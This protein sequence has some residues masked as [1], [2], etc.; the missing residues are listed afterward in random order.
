MP[1]HKSTRL[2][3]TAGALAIVVSSGWSLS[4]AQ[5][6]PV[7]RA[8]RQRAEVLGTDRAGGS[9]TVREDE[10]ELGD[11]TPFGVDVSGLRL[12]SHQD[13]ATM[14]PTVSEAI[15]IDPELPA[16]AGL[17]EVLQ[18]Y[19]G[20]PLSMALLGRLG[21]D[22]VLAWRESDYPLVDVYFPEQNITQGKIQVVVREAVLGE[23]RQEGAVHSRPDYILENLRLESGDR[24][25][26]RVVQGDLDWLN[27][28]P[29]RQVNVI[30]ERGTEDGTSDIVMDVNE[31]KQL[32][33]Y[34]SFA[35]TGVE[36]T[37]ENEFS[38]G[39]N[40]ANPWQTEQGI[41]YQYTADID[42][43]YLNAHTLFYQN[44][45]PWRHT[46][47]IIGAYVTSEARGLGPLGLNGESSQVSTE[48][49]VPLPRPDWNRGW[50]HAVTAAFDYKATNTDLIFGGFNV[51]ASDIAIGQFRFEYD[52]S[53]PDRFGYSRFSAGI[54][55]SPGDMYGNNDD[56]SFMLARPGSEADYFYSFVECEKL[57]RLPQD[58]SLRLN[59]NAQ[60][61]GDRL[62]STEQLLAGGYATVRGY[63]E[64]VVRGDAGAIFNVEVI[65]PPFSL[66]D[67]IEDE[68]NAFVFY[69]GAALQIEDKLPGEFSPSLQSVGLGLN[70]RFSDRGFA[71]ASY[72]WAI[73]NHGVPLANQ[74]DGRFHFGV[75]LT[76]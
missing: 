10:D 42:F 24:I 17:E 35:N 37:G 7:E 74:G 63:D 67:E 34:T 38:F 54:V 11:D 30:Y 53:F 39:V 60:A 62:A 66:C 33:A 4:H 13:K 18:P 32:T 36:F 28:N 26:R 41:G 69:D 73:D 55:G 19:I 65:T 71:R 27:E 61:S 6:R 22:I 45:L 20:E 1:K 5:N 3:F 8:E 15:V 48:Y 76:Y 44:F 40:L 2:R 64:S 46:L 51:F 21:K 31:E 58:W 68:W 52:A 14:D 75:T 50:R 47:N 43:D 29:I 12:I 16:P 23:K 72:G 9:E 25:N 56:T 57:I 70:C 59:T 49:R